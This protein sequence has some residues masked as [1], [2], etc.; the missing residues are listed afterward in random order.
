ML[1]DERENNLLFRTNQIDQIIACQIIIKPPITLNLPPK[2]YTNSKRH[3]NSLGRT[4]WN[5]NHLNTIYQT[6]DEKLQVTNKLEIDSNQ[7]SH[8]LHKTPSKSKITFR[9]NIFSLEEYLF[10]R[11]CQEKTKI[12]E[13]AQLSQIRGR[14]GFSITKG[15]S[16]GVR[17]S[18]WNW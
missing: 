3:P 2:K 5:P 12:S 16:R 8:K 10:C 6:L 1:V 11:I 4:T 13:G 18:T 9:L 7:W 17:E 14:L 15:G